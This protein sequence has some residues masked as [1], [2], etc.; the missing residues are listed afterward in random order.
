MDRFISRSRTCAAVGLCTSAA[1]AA[2]AVATISAWLITA[3]RTLGVRHPPT[4]PLSDAIAWICVPLKPLPMRSGTAAV[5]AAAAAGTA[6]DPIFATTFG[7]AAADADDA[8]LD[9]PAMPVRPAD[10]DLALREAGTAADFDSAAADWVGPATIWL[11]AR[12]SAADATRARGGAVVG[13]AA[14]DLADAGLGANTM[15]T[16]TSCANAEASAET[17]AESDDDDAPETPDQPLSPYDSSEG[18]EAEDLFAPPICTAAD[19]ATAA[20]DMNRSISVSAGARRSDATDN[21]AESFRLTLALPPLPLAIGT[22]KLPYRE[23]VLT[24]RLRGA[25]LV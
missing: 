18:H 13:A 17:R 8:A 14:D 25:T 19:G 23:L 12:P 7:G 5:G 21:G 1:A 9:L 22:A 6:F 4:A 2:A 15:S 20:G 16:A 3:S 24:V 11:A 10:A